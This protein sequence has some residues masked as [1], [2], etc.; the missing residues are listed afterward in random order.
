MGFF[1]SDQS[2]VRWEGPPPSLSREHGVLPGLVDLSLVMA[3]AERVVLVLGPIEVWPS[4]ALIRLS[5]VAR[6]PGTALLR[7]LDPEIYAEAGRSW[8][9]P[10]LLRFGVE[11]ADGRRVT[12][13]TDTFPPRVD[14][15][16]ILL[17]HR[18]ESGGSGG[19]ESEYWLSPVPPP[20]DVIVACQWPEYDIAET[21]P[22]LPAASFARPQRE[23]ECSGLTAL[24]I[25]LGN[26]GRRSRH[27]RFGTALVVTSP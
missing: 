18:G 1:D 5:V 22:R 11:Y 6:E 25:D 4:G 15:A 24:P 23:R 27:C 19:F 8:P 26:R 16:G 12:N 3:R 2:E 10:E 14:A 13:L 21:H 20:G 9:P 7:A 17:F